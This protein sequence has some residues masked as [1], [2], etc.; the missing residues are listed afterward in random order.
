MEWLSVNQGMAVIASHDSE[1][2]EIAGE[3]YCNY[4]FRESIEDGKVLF[5]Y[6][7]HDGPS[8][9]RNAIKLLEVLDSPESVTT[10]ANEMARHFT[11]VHEWE[12]ISNRL[13]QLS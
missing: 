13:T 7:V 12:K 2:T 5:D 11:D 8:T 10:Q 9:T 3:L 1:L 6:K 4:H